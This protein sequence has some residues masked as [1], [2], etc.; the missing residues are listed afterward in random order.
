MVDEPQKTDTGSNAKASSFGLEMG[1][2]GARAGVNEVR[3]RE[4]GFRECTEKIERTLPLLEFGGENNDGVIRG[5]AP[6]RAKG[7]AID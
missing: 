5:N 1:K 4:I 7:C 3:V 2:K 6:R